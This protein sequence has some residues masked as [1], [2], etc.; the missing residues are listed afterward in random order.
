M[1]SDRRYIAKVDYLVARSQLE[2]LEVFEVLG[3]L[4]SW[5]GSALRMGVPGA[6]QH[7]FKA[8]AELLL[9]DVRIGRMDWG[10]EAMRGW[11]RVDIPGE[12]CSWID[13][14][15]VHHL[16]A[17]AQLRR[18]D[19]CVTFTDGSVTHEHVLQAY[20]EGGFSGRAGGRPPKCRRV[21][22]EGDPWAGR[23]IYLG[24][25]G[26]FKFVRAYDKGLEVLARE[27]RV[28]EADSDGAGV[29]VDGWPAKDVYRIEVEYHAQ[30]KVPLPWGMV[31]DPLGYWRG[32]YP[33]LA[34]LVPGERVE[35]SAPERPQASSDLEVALQT[36]RKQ[37]GAVL[38]TALTVHA[39]DIG[40][41]FD[42]VCGN[43][44]S[45]RLLRAGVLLD[46]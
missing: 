46:A 34:Q 8:G 14:R 17:V 26:G 5:S 6:G 37:W 38:Y 20:R 24:T 29:L 18:C 41:V 43:E 40:A 31:L 4:V 28:P 10:G 39:G 9:S 23:T 22:P 32:A 42:K 27:R 45:E 30:G 3:R 15:E 19:P 11:V 16:A 12:G 33:W 13:W 25:R 21:E 36:I 1:T 35:L 7:G 44:H 2:V